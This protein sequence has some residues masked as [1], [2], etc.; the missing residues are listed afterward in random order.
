MFTRGANWAAPVRLGAPRWAHRLPRIGFA[1]PT[2]AP[3]RWRLTAQCRNQ[4]RAASHLFRESAAPPPATTPKRADA[5]VGASSAAK[6][7]SGRDKA[8]LPPAAS[9]KKRVGVVS[10][11][12]PPSP[13]RRPRLAAR[14]LVLRSRAPQT[15]SRPTQAPPAAFARRL[16][17][18][19][20]RIQTRAASHLLRES[21][22]HP[23]RPRRLE[24]F[25]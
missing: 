13:T 9:R 15:T 11:L 22:A 4:T 8:R 20:R 23:P 17:L 3:M 10:S 5:A 2:T 7:A 18:G 12:S 1:L 6:S 14:F 21:V 25:S 19:S 24:R 16:G